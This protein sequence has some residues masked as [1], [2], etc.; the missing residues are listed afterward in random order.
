MGS[1]RTWIK[2]L[3]AAIV[4]SAANTITVMIVAPETFNLTSA[5]GFRKIGSVALVSAIVGAAAYL[6]QS[7]VPNDKP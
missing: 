3:V 4:S 1:L 5:G 2:G 6:K 7:P